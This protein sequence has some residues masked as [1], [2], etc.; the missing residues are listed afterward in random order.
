MCKSTLQILAASFLVLC[1]FKATA[2][3]YDGVCIKAPAIAHQESDNIVRVAS[4][5]QL[6]QAMR[7]VS[8]DSVILI[9]PGA[10][11]L[12]RTLWV[13]TNNVTIR[14]DSDRCDDIVLIGEGMENA[15]GL[16][17]VPHGIWT[18]AANTRVTR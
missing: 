14:G 8:E 4:E 17:S 15:A 18:N 3:D 9:A 11:K 13:Q 10:Y 1:S 5:S 16:D 12:T 7:S 6:Q 2:A